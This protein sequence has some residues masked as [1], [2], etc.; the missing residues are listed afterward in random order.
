MRTKSEIWKNYGV[1]YQPHEVGGG[2]DQQ[3]QTKSKYCKCSACDEP[4]IAA[5]GRL[6]DHWNKCNKRPRAIGQLDAGFETFAK[7]GEEA[8]GRRTQC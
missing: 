7:C 4:I 2:T 5:S 3:H 8:E 6:R 1:V